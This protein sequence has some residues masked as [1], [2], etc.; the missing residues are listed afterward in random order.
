MT[1]TNGRA[2]EK[3]IIAQVGQEFHRLMDPDGLLPSSQVPTTGPYSEPTESTQHPRTLFL[4]DS[5]QY[6]LPIYARISS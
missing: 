2:L 5:F 1:F 6:Y 3:L 4:S